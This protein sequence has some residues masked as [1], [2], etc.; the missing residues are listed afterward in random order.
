M[1]MYSKC[2]CCVC[3]NVLK[4]DINPCMSVSVL[5]AH[6]CNVNMQEFSIEIGMMYIHLENNQRLILKTEV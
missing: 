6:T 5:N 4:K 1:Y 2:M 3:M